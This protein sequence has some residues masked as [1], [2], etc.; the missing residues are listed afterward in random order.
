MG[1]VE[2]SMRNNLT[3]TPIRM[4]VDLFMGQC[5]YKMLNNFWIDRQILPKLSLIASTVEDNYKGGDC[6]QPECLNWSFILKIYYLGS[7]LINSQHRLPSWPRALQP[8]RPSWWAAEC[9]RRSAVCPSTGSRT[10]S[11]PSAVTTSE[12]KKKIIKFDRCDGSLD[13]AFLNDHAR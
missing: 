13:N 4:R 9:S 10:C 5:F 7:S 1:M 12:M 2:I 6:N 8:K 11:C 3:C